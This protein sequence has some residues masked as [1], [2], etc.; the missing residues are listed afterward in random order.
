MERL[1]FIM[2]D[3]EG[4]L[5]PL[6]R[7][8]GATSLPFYVSRAKKKKLGKFFGG[9]TVRYMPTPR[10]WASVGTISCLSSLHPPV[11]SPKISPPDTFCPKVSTSV[12]NLA[13][14]SLDPA[15]ATAPWARRRERGWL[16]LRGWDRQYGF[17][18]FRWGGKT[19]SWPLS[20][21]VG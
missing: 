11:T 20:A 15:N 6:A 4:R 12:D 16:Q 9:R 8:S 10:S 17:F 18:H 3:A 5:T 7:K 14:D 21:A 19:S 2:R 1:Q 13:A